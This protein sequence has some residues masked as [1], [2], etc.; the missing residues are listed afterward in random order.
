MVLG[1]QFHDSFGAEPIKSK[2]ISIINKRAASDKPVITGDEAR[3]VF[4]AANV[5]QWTSME[6]QPTIYESGVGMYDG[7]RE[8]DEVLHTAQK[9]LH[10]PTLQKYMRGE[11]PEYDPDYADDSGVSEVEYYPEVMTTRRGTPFIGEGHHRFVASRLQD[12]GTNTWESRT[13]E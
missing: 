11:V 1:P 9:H 2:A 3:T 8:P 10:T 12:R 6:D 4:R 5:R 7:W 13:N